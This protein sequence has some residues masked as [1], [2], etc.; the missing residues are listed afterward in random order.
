MISFQIIKTDYDFLQTVG[1]SMKEGRNFS[2][3]FAT[4]SLHYIIN[5]EAAKR[6]GMREA[7]GQR[8]KLWDKEG[9]VIGVVKDF[10]FNSLH[11]RIMPAIIILRPK[12]TYMLYVRTKPGQAQQAVASLQNLH[13]QYVPEY[14]FEYNFLDE[15]FDRMYRGDILVGKLATCFSFITIFI[16]CLGLF[17]LAAYT[18][19]KR[20]KEVGIRKVL[21]ASVPHIVA[22]LSK[23]FLKLVLIAIVI[24]LPLAWWVMS[25]WLENFE[26]QTAIEWWMP[27]LAGIA[28]LLIA[29]L[30]VS[31]Q[32]IKA[33]IANPVKSLRSE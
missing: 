18:A 26:Y 25:K 7:V 31:Y 30:T 11:A 1:A 20:V 13:K 29:I 19:E 27:A 6:M 24:S 8:L 5:E 14:P 32:S 28:A 21:G 10:H 23:D 16:S 22:L 9:K 33:A 15:G 12:E 2:R 17:G 4:D 3:E